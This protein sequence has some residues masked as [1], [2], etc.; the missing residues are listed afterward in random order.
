MRGDVGGGGG[1]SIV[2]GGSL[3]LQQGQGP[4]HYTTGVSRQSRGMV[5][6]HSLEP[7]G[8][9]A[10]RPVTS[11]SPDRSAA[12]NSGGLVEPL[13]PAA[14]RA[15]GV[16]LQTLVSS[17][18]TASGEGLAT[19]VTLRARGQVTSGVF[20]FPLDAAGFLES[21]ALAGA[22]TSRTRQCGTGT[23]LSTVIS[24]SEVEERTE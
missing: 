22:T 21:V 24:E 14:G 7:P 9:T 3:A 5:T 12:S 8:V 15:S 4:E 17:L 18:T 20:D 16:G 1:R 6:K 19:L 13:G 2:E 10:P 23:W 11:S